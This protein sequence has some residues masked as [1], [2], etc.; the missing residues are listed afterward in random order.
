MRVFINERSLHEQYYQDEQMEQLVTSFVKSAELIRKVKTN[1]NVNLTASLYW[2]RPMVG[3]T[4]S[5]SLRRNPNWNKL[6][7]ENLQSLSPTSWDDS[8]EHDYGLSYVYNDDE[9]VGSSVAEISHRKNG[10][11][12]FLG[13][14]LNFSD[15][16]FST[17]LNIEVLIDNQH[18]VVV[19]CA[20]SEDSVFNWLLSH[21]YIEE[22][23]PYDETSGLPPKDHQTILGDR[24]KFEPTKYRNQERIVFRKIGTNQLWCVDRSRRHANVR[25]HLEVFDE[26]TA[27]HLGTSL[28]FEDNLNTDYLEDERTINLQ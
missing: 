21:G 23:D 1:R 13:F 6:F 18:R 8:P 7:L 20:D 19:D 10:D 11:A 2:S 25:A 9:Y 12:T 15:S 17:L 28:Y 22:S 4:L 3:E 14:L 5:A 27:R 26:N 16:V 24:T